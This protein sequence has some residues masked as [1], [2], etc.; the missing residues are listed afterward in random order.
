MSDSI[1]QA[2]ASFQRWLTAFNTRDVEGMIADMHF[3]HRRLSGENDFQVWEAADDFRANN[4]ISIA[5]RNTQGW[6]YNV[7]NSIDAI[8]SG[9]DKVHLAIN[10]ARCRAD[11]TEYYAFPSLWI[12]TRIDDHWGVQFRSSFLSGPVAR[13]EAVE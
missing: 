8:Q 5:A 11:G 2:K 3:P 12:F 10:Y 4:E 7:A 13:G 6:G 9:A 1:V